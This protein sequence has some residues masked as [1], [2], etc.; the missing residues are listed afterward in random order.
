[1]LCCSNARFVLYESISGW[2]AE[3]RTE[4]RRLCV[5][6]LLLDVSETCSPF[7]NHVLGKYFQQF[8]SHFKHLM[9]NL[10]NINNRKSTNTHVDYLSF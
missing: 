8:F 7:K 4:L 3:L 1:M 9:K 5:A 2:G 10:R 6:A